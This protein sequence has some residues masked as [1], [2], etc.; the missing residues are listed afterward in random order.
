MTSSASQPLPPGRAGRP[1]APAADQQ[2]IRACLTDDVAAEFDAEYAAAL[3]EA[4]DSHD[5]AEVYALLGRWRHL[6]HAELAVPGDYFRVHD[7]ATHAMTVGHAPG[8]ALSDDE[9]QTMIR[10]RLGPR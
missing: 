7:T 2:A 3:E 6:A 4:E 5:L 1:P 10:E 8:G 9:M